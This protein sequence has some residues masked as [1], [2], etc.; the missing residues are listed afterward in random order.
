[1]LENVRLHDDYGP[2]RTF[3]C[4]DK[5]HVTGVITLKHS[6]LITKYYAEFYLISVVITT[7]TTPTTP[8]TTTTG[9]PF[10]CYYEGRLYYPYEKI[11]SGGH[12][13]GDSCHKHGKYCNING[14]IIS[15]DDWTC[16]G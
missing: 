8:R 9:M 11:S 13:H 1:M 10:G 12:Q 4:S 2:T 14:Q 16:T 15:W 5:S 3:N 6:K 7:P